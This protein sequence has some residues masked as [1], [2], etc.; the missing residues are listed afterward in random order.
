MINGFICTNI[1]TRNSKEL[2]LFY[3]KTLEIP[4]IKTDVDDYNGVYLGFIED[5]P[6]ICIWDCIWCNLPS[7]GP[8]SFV[9]VCDN[10]DDTIVKLK[11]KGLILALPK[12]YE[13]GTYELR[14][15]DPDGNEVV[16]VEYFDTT[17][18]LT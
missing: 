4:I 17:L 5:A 9:F 3:N 1:F 11:N 8:N 13:W 7:T 6:L 10:L 14:V 16:I 12:K 2:T 18:K 15:N